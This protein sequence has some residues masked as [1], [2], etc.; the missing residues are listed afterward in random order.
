MNR[1]FGNVIT[2]EGEH[3]L[4]ISINADMSIIRYYYHAISII[5]KI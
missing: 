5:L 4:V 1:A 3:N 2:V